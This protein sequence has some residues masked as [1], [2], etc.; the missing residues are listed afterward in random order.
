MKLEV[1][2]KIIAAGL[3][4]VVA[5]C[6]ACGREKEESV[7]IASQ[8]QTMQT[9][10]V[11]MTMPEENQNNRLAGQYRMATNGRDVYI[12][13]P[14]DRNYT[15]REKG[16]VEM[17]TDYEKRMITI[18]SLRIEKEAE[19]TLQSV[20]EKVIEHEKL[21]LSAYWNIGETSYTHQDK[22]TINGIEMLRCEG[23]VKND[24]GGVYDAYIVGY[25]FLIEDTPCSVI[26]FVKDK[27]Q[28]QDIINE[29]RDYVDAMVKTIKVNA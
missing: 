12:S 1:V 7:I 21:A 17:F 22:M 4:F 23:M 11:D 18:A 14:A 29:V 10:N 26:G 24:Y 27:E 13:T 3:V 8:E 2:K 5:G 16:F 15:E 25:Y 20:Y 19:Y 9:K 28:P 6:T